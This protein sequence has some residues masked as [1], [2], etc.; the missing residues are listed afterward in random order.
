MTQPLRLCVRRAPLPGP[1]EPAARIT[2]QV[3]SEVDCIEEAVSV[4][5]RHCL[6]GAFASPRM[7]FRLRVALSEALANAIVRGNREDRTKRVY[8]QAD[9]TAEL[10]C[11]LVTD[12]GEGFDPRDMPDAASDEGVLQDGGRGLF[13]IH[14]MVDDVHFNAQG[15][16]ICM[17]L[18][19][20]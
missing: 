16:A 3:P 1:A 2:V 5:L 4:I 10:I 9:L 12:E 14:H 6:A 7:Q 17:T 13:L 15:N 19:R 8:V 11:L 18:R 20:P